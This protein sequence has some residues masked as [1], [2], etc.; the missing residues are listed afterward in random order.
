MQLPWACPFALL[1]LVAGAS[2]LHTALPRGRRDADESV[3]QLCAAEP[4]EYR[5][6]DLPRLLPPSLARTRTAKELQREKF[7]AAEYMQNLSHV[8]HC[9]IRDSLSFIQPLVVPRLKLAFCYIPKVACTQFKDL[10]NRLNNLSSP[11]GFGVTYGDSMPAQ[12]G[13]PLARVSRES[14]WKFAAF[15]RDP[16]LR[17]LSAWGSTCVSTASETPTFEHEDECCGPKVMDNSI[18]PD[19]IISMFE[20]RVMSDLRDGIV[21]M[22]QHWVEQVQVLKQCGWDL[23]NP[24]NLDF[25]GHLHS[26]MNSQVKDML[27]MVGH[28]DDLL[29]D[30]FFPPS[31]RI[32]GHRSPLSPLEP[33]DYYRARETLEAVKTIYEDDYQTFESIGCSFTEPTLASLREKGNST[34]DFENHQ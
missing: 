14:G 32:A 22:E 17:Y 20:L 7:D 31:G 15:T 2:A 30:R 18:N 29:V 16:A 3:G 13:L 6:Q 12:L 9:A 25:H 33:E 11:E 8:R 34:A 27:R 26:D 24:G 28:S 23:F 5:G 10:F 4:P 1:L 19:T 21:D